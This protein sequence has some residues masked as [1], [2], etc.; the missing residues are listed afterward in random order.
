[1]KNISSLRLTLIFILRCFL[2]YFCIE[3]K[4]INDTCVSTAIKPSGASRLNPG[5]QGIMSCMGD[6]WCT[7]SRECKCLPPTNMSENSTLLSLPNRNTYRG[8]P[9]PP[10]GASTNGNSMHTDQAQSSKLGQHYFKFRFTKPTPKTCQNRMKL[11]LSNFF[12]PSGLF[13]FKHLFQN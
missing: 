4:W 1:M 6:V 5:Q 3:F 8:E 13:T 2:C 11:K 12:I 7:N 10:T 9:P